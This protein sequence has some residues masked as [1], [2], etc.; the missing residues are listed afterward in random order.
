M[1]RMEKTRLGWQ[2]QR[3][4]ADDASRR[5]AA[6]ADLRQ[7][8]LRHGCSQLAQRRRFIKPTPCAWHYLEATSSEDREVDGDLAGRGEWLGRRG[9]R[10]QRKY[11]GQTKTTIFSLSVA[12]IVLHCS[13]CAGECWFFW[14]SPALYA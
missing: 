13:S 8:T 9:A 6:M 14:Q 3:Y 1:K 7:C 2:I 12:L 4:T 11:T 10:W 5:P